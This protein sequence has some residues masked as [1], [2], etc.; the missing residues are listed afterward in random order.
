ML[1]NCDG[2]S[3]VRT[4]RFGLIYYIL[5]LELTPSIVIAIGVLYESIYG[6]RYIIP[7]ETDDVLVIIFVVSDSQLL[8]HACVS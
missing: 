5:I 8:V 2:F 4:A 7:F 1:V 6:E 3:V